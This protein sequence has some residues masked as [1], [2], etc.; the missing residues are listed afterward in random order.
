M[1]ESEVYHVRAEKI[2]KRLTM[3]VNDEEIF[4]VEDPNPLEGPERSGIGIYSWGSDIWYDNIKIYTLGAPIK[5]DIMELAERF[6]RTGHYETSIDLFKDIIA[7]TTERKRRTRAYQGLK[8]ARTEVQLRKTYDKYMA[9]LTRYW[10][11]ENIV[12]S[13]ENRSFILSLN[14]ENISS[15]KPLVNM[16]LKKLSISNTRLDSLAY[17]PNIKVESLSIFNSPVRKI[18][19]LTNP[20]LKSISFKDTKISD[21]SPLKKLK[22]KSIEFDLTGIK[23]GIPELLSIQTLEAINT[24]ELGKLTIKEF[25]EKYKAYRALNKAE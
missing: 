12:L 7:S 17:L 11:P 3:I 4:S 20:E 18:P 19:E 21:L 8:N 5:V 23:D 14:G 16:K 22:I 10:Q 13:I 25:K 15:L 1:E 6:L 24:P 2:G 9:I